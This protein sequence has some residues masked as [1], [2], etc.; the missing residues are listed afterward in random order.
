[1]DA[2]IDPIT[3]VADQLKLADTL[4]ARAAEGLPLEW[5]DA[6]SV[7][8]GTIDGQHRVLIAYINQLSGAITRTQSSAQLGQVLVGLEGYTRLH[9]HYE[10]RLFKRL[11]WPDAEEHA[12]AHRMFE[13]QLGDFRTRFAGGDMSVGP[14]VLNFMV[15][16]LTGHI[17]SEDMSYSEFLRAHH[18]V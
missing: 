12:L 9:F 17:L 7:G 18:V 6:L 4:A 10:E 8:V 16:W 2:R 11:G 14:Q 3:S 13:R 1:M 15:R 5:S